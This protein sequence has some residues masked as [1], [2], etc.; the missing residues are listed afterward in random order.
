[1]PAYLIKVT[2]ASG[3]AGI[4]ASLSAEQAETGAGAFLRDLFELEGRGVREVCVAI[5]DDPPDE[6]AQP[7]PRRRP[8]RPSQEGRQM[9]S[10]WAGSG[11]SPY[12]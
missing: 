1:M 9:P 11:K 12:S 6:A 8:P 10:Q 7:R 4:H 3:S 5:Q 2:Y